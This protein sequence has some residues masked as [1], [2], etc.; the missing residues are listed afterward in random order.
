M[1]R[2]I[3]TLALLTPLI[4]VSVSISDME[5]SKQHSNNSGSK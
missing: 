5:T 2:F 4:F 1:G 3:V